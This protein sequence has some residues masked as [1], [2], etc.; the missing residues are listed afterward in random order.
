VQPS[1]CCIGCKR[2]IE[3][4]RAT[5]CAASRL[6]PSSFND[7]NNRTCLFGKYLISQDAKARLA[8]CRITAHPSPQGPWQTSGSIASISR[9]V[10][11]I[12][13]FGH[14][15]LALSSASTP[16]VHHHLHEQPACAVF[17][18]LVHGSFWAPHSVCSPRHLLHLCPSS[19]STA[20]GRT[21]RPQSACTQ[22]TGMDTAIQTALCVMAA[23]APCVMIV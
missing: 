5:L 18:N 6:V 1:W 11:S 10:N 21:R 14:L 23:L 17:M 19:S 13:E 16:S 7:S 12:S 4:I 20:H 3:R 8:P 9:G 22:V 15:F 2:L